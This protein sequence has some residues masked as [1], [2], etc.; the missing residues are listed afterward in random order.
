M[1]V[2]NTNIMSINAQRNLAGTQGGLQTAMERL[3]S[4]LRINSA[5]DDAAGLAIGKIMES[6]VNVIN[7]GIRNANDG[8]SM[9]QTAE[10][11]LEEVHVMLQRMEQL[12]MQAA[13]DTLGEDERDLIKLEIDELVDEISAIADR[14]TFGGGDSLLNGDMTDGIIIQVGQGTGDQIELDFS[15]NVSDLPGLDAMAVDNNANAVAAMGTIREA[16]NQVSE[17]RAE[18]GAAQNRLEHNVANLRVTAENLEAAKSQIMDADFAQETANL[19]RAQ[20]LQQAGTA[21]L[22]QANVAPQNVLSLLQ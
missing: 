4:G 8:I 22:A 10:G 13:N 21:M 15:T 16:I 20:V 3:S 19:T 18:F 1:S 7:Q 14:T 5:K 6:Q 9:I 17:I 12:A 11:A 2:I